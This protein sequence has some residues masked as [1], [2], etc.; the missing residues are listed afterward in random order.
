MGRIVIDNDVLWKPEA[1]ARLRAISGSKVLPALAFGERARQYALQGRSLETLRALLSDAGVFIEPM[2]PVEAARC[3]INVRNGADWHHLNRDAFIAGH[4][5]PG[6][7]LWTGDV[8]DFVK[9]GVPRSRI[10]A[11]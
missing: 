10:V 9:V 6:D 11:A 5:G 7:V 3:T 4:V 8:A 2:G 1:L